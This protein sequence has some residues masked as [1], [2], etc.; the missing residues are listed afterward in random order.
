MPALD[1]VGPR[2]AVY[3]E[4]LGGWIVDTSGAFSWHADQAQWFTSKA[5]VTEA[6]VAMKNNGHVIHFVEC[7]IV[8][9]R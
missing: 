4:R 2:W 7:A 1:N 3:N 9:V 8:R 6:I 5:E